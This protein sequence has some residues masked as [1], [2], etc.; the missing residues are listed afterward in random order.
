MTNI[1]VAYDGRKFQLLDGLCGG[2]AAAPLVQPADALLLNWWAEQGRGEVTTCHDL[3]GTLSVI[4]HANLRAVITDNY[5]HDLRVQ[6][7]YRANELGPAPEISGPLDEGE[8]SDLTVMRAPKS[9]A[10]F[11]LYL[12]R[13]ARTAGANTRLAV[14]FMTR[15]FS[16]RLLEIAERYAGEVRQ[17]RAHKKAR[18]LLL[19]D[20]KKGA[21]AQVQ[22][23]VLAYGQQQYVQYPGVFSADHID[24]ATQ[25][26]LDAW[27]TTEV[28]REMTAPQRI[29]DAACGNG[30]IGDQLLRRHPTAELLAYD[31]SRVAVASARE[32][33]AGYGDRARVELGA[34]LAP[35]VAPDSQDLI[36][37]N[38]PFH[39]GHRNDIG[40]SLELFTEAKAALRT[41]GKFVVVANR[42]LN[43]GTHLQRLFTSGEMA[44]EHGKFEVYVAKV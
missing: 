10:L 21:G 34:S 28:L 16:P 30:I 26:L 37:T 4:T 2:T 5:V 29:V 6:Q 11:E 39:D 20:F 24:Y 43:Y 19:S 15:H 32:N 17:S 31:V 27:E 36:V 18:L 41:G 13:I 22:K 7:L 44:V 14:G 33:L 12:R 40:P 25:L 23:T 9:L 35:L 1:S 8:G 38:P 42:H 3:S